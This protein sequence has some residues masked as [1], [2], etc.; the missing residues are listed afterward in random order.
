MEKAVIDKEIIGYLAEIQDELCRLSDQI[1]DFAEPG[2]QEVR[3]CALL[4]EYLGRNGFAVEHGVG[5]LETAFRAVYEKGQGGPS[6][7]FLAE[8]D[9]L[10]G[11]GHG[12]GHHMQGPSVTGAALTVKHLCEQR[13]ELSA[14]KLVVYGTPAEETVGGKTT[15]LEYGCFQD[16]DIALMMHGAPDTCVDVKSMASREYQV[17]FHGKKSHAAMYPELGRSALD[18]VLLAC[19]GIEC[20]REHV[21]EDTRM[22]YTILD[23][24]GPANVV[25]DRASAQFVIRSYD[26]DYLETLVPRVEDIW[27]GACLM[28]G[29][30]C[31]L[32]GTDRFYGKIP[33]PRLNRLIMEQAKL[34]KAPQLAPPREKTGST[35]FGIVMYHMPGCCIR[36]AFVPHGTPAHSQAFLE[37]GKSRK[38]HEAVVFGSKIL[39][40]TCLELLERPELLKDI[41]EEFQAAKR[42]MG[43]V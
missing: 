6:F 19:H 22:H 25:P 9:A 39:A 15:M 10:E 29:T 24:G 20:L 30:T 33:C 14:W 13:P 26:T 38:A 4:E 41:R 42:D 7:G 1:Y 11:M 2:L 37:A 40:G 27:K 36:V 21:R 3:S 35:D 8:Y 32:L 12:C 43:A 5:G 16:I 31:E 17:C 18:A 34:F 23:A 28:T